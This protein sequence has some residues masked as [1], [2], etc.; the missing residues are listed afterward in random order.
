M[1]RRTASPVLSSAKY[2]ALAAYLAFA[3]FPLYW[4]VKIAITPASPC[5]S[6]RGP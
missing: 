4:L 6:W 2:L 5:G 1:A 3:L